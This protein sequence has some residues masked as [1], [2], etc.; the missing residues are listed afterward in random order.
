MSADKLTGAL[1]TINPLKDAQIGSLSTFASIGLVIGIVIIIMFLILVIIWM[2]FIKRQYWITIKVFRNIGNNPTHVATYKAREVHFGFAGDKIWRVAPSS[3]LSMAFQIIKWIPVGKFQTAPREFWYWIRKD[4]EWVNFRPVDID[5][6]SGNMGVEFIQ[7]DMRLQ[8]L[9]TEKILEQR[10][11]NKT[12]WEK[13]GLIVGYLVFFLVITVAM[14]IIF[15]QWSKLIDKMN[16]LVSMIA[17][18]YSKCQASSN[19]PTSLIPISP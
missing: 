4:N 8:R 5:V 17:D 2:Y 18:A 3:P 19:T 14:I 13:Y 6:V 15:Y 1:S 12:F 10:L 7:E 9:A 11:L 16:P